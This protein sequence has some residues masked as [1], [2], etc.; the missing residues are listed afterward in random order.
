MSHP[1]LRT[2]SGSTRTLGVVCHPL[3]TPGN[4]HPFMVRVL[5]ASSRRSCARPDPVRLTFIVLVG[6]G[7]SSGSYPSSPFGA[8]TMT[9]SI[10]VNLMCRKYHPCLS[11][12]GN[13]PQGPERG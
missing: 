11:K 12:S 5:D 13:Q 10:H 1:T 7:A 9:L 4:H 3:F 6:L 8:P 2:P